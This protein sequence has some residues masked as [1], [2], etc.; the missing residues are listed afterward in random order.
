MENP[1][2]RVEFTIKEGVT[3]NADPR[4]VEIALENLIGNAWKY[5]DKQE[6]STIEFSV[7]KCDGGQA[8]FVRDNG[9]GFDM[10]EATRLF[11]TLQRL[12][13][14]GV[15]EGYGIGLATVQRIVKRHGGTCGRK[16]S[17]ERCD[18]FLYPVTY[19]RESG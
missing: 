6:V 11:G 14:E 15:F 19:H 4:L 3:V 5:T 7:A 17:G 2:R 1:D 10:K 8:C 9:F 18:I 12:H 16:G 13:P